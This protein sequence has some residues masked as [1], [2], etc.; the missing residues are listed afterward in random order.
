[1]NYIPVY[2]GGSVKFIQTQE[3]TILTDELL[4]AEKLLKGRP[5]RAVR[6]NQNGNVVLQKS[7]VILSIP[8]IALA[9]RSFYVAKETSFWFYPIYDNTNN[10][11]LFVS[12]RFCGS[13]CIVIDMMSGNRVV[14]E[15]KDITA[16]FYDLM[17]SRTN[18]WYQLSELFRALSGCG[19]ANRDFIPAII[20]NRDSDTEYYALSPLFTR[21]YENIMYLTEEDINLY[22][23]LINGKCTDDDIYVQDNVLYRP[24]LKYWRPMSAYYI[25]SLAKKLRALRNGKSDYIA[26]VSNET[27]DDY[28]YVSTDLRH[29]VKASTF[30]H[31]VIGSAYVMLFL[32]NIVSR[33]MLPYQ[34]LCEVWNMISEG[35]CCEEENNT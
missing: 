25:L 26:I 11:R 18:T 35:G 29:V 30:E 21:W 5:S 9:L 20:V 2:C 31:V 13:S 32:K 28:M 7:H 16:R 6:F 27:G 22:T 1:M 33:R 12:K 3:K 14:V 19:N 17:Q 4:E 24:G 8:E 34:E 10:C 23:N 15:E